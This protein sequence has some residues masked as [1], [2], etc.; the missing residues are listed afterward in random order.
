MSNTIAVA[1]QAKPTG[2]INLPSDYQYHDAKPGS[3]AAAKPLFGVAPVAGDA[4]ASFAAWMTDA[5]NPR[6]ARVIAN[7]MWLRVFGRPAQ[8]PIDN[9]T[10]ADAIAPTPLMAE[11]TRLMV[12]LDFDL[13]RFESV[14]LR[15]AAFARSATAD[16][17]ATGAPAIARLSAE[18]M[19]DSLLTLI[20]P[21]I[22][23]Q[24]GEQGAA[25]YDFYTKH[26][27]DDAETL[28]TLIKDLGATR[29]KQEALN[30]ELEALKPQLAAA[31]GDEA[32]TL[33]AKQEDL[34]SQRDE[35]AQRTDMAR[36]VAPKRPKAESQPLLRA[37]ELPQ[38]A[39]PGHFL[40]VFGQSDR[41][42]ID[43]S[44]RAPT[45]PQALTLLNGFID[46]EVLR[47]RTPLIQMALAAPDEGAR[48]DL[49][50][51][52]ILTRLPTAEER[53]LVTVAYTQAGTGAKS[54]KEAQVAGIRRI[55][56]ALLNSH[57]F[58]TLP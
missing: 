48:I 35:L 18:Q 38:P 4:R 43:G 45:T 31:K 28:T 15:T 39:P 37:A 34:R 3:A 44:S 49:L 9:L 20:D 23:A 13:V 57:A 53:A 22:D 56:W 51:R 10:G 21:D 58:R 12:A 19:W 17:Q 11:L 26:H 36:M 46:K 40:R 33:K 41:E 6:F 50:Y 55:A 8:D 32:K 25:L 16:E 2:T 27:D 7:R 30:A 29:A 1:V 24:V 42:R 54:P 52:A 5:N 47:E 14:L